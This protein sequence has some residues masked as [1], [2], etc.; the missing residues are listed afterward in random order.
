MNSKNLLQ[1][2]CQKRGLALPKYETGLAGGMAHNPRFVS[3]VI[4]TYEETLYKVTGDTAGNKK[5]AEMNAA[6]MLLSKLDA[7]QKEN[8][9]HYKPSTRSAIYVMIDLE[10]IHVGD[11]FDHKVFHRSYSEF[12]FVGCATEGH[13]SLKNIQSSSGND[14]IKIISIKSSHKD[15]TDTLMIFGVGALVSQDNTA[16][17]VIVT[18]DHFGAPLVEI[19]NQDESTGY[20]LKSMEELEDWLE[21]YRIS[22]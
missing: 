10:N 3:S 11:F 22:Q 2:F 5:E 12:S 9:K 1:E 13:P 6:E 20:H 19:I 7:V 14:I 4:V 15:A 16:I 17:F 18:K 8:T 21:Q